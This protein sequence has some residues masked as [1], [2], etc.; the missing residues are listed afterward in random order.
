M[1]AIPILLGACALLGTAATRATDFKQVFKERAADAAPQ[2]ATTAAP[3]PAAAA[4][5]PAGAQAAYKKAGAKPAAAVMA[6]QNAASPAAAAAAPAPQQPVDEIARGEELYRRGQISGAAR[7]FEAR[8]LAEPTP[9]EQSS[10]LFRLGVQWQGEMSKAAAHQRAEVR[11]AAIS[12]YQQTLRINPDSGAA[13]N[14]LAQM[15]KA[16]ATRAAE[17][18]SLLARAIALGDSRKGVYLMN[19]AANRRDAGD[20]AAA[21]L[22]AQQAAADDKGNLGAHDLVMDL[23]EKRQDARALLAYIHDLAARGLVVRAL[24]SAAR[25]MK[26]LPEARKQLLTAVASTISSESYTADPWEF[27]QT[28]AGRAIA[29]Y[30]ADPVIGGGV[31]ELFAVL[32]APRPAESLRWWREGH[33]GFSQPPAGSPAEAMQNLM[34][35]CGEI[36]Q[37][38]GDQRAEGYYRMGVWLG[39]RR[40]IDPRALLGLAEIL[41]ERG[42]LDDLNQ[43]LTENEPGLMQ[44]KGETIAAADFYHTYQ[45]RLAL[46]MMYGYVERWRNTRAPIYAASIW[47]L[48]H[49]EESADIYNDE[50]RLPPPERIKLPPSAVKMLSTGY[51]KTNDIRRSVEVRLRYADRYLANGQKRFAQQVLDPDWRKSLPDTLDAALKQRV[52]EV[53]ARASAS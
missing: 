9:A 31:N 29:S 39:G 48:E 11:D 20:L 21:T 10:T 16:D 50:A 7:I 52:A 8:A 4:V 46:G 47:M 2:A 25:G 1:R 26:S 18:D 32:H 19:R 5:K 53:S 34:R 6:G 15:L 22:Y 30:R 42:R 44:A 14:N 51:A 38:A 27:D 43:L 36:Y 13:L 23:L 45:L 40:N 35:R 37:L 33:N 41:Y 3:A 28:D 12:A 49:A 24:D 17:A